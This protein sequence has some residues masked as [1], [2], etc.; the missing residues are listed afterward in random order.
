[1]QLERPVKQ[2]LKILTIVGVMAFIWLIKVTFFNI[3]NAAISHAQSRPDSLSGWLRLIVSIASLLGF[4]LVCCV[5]AVVLV[6]ILASQLLEEIDKLSLFDGHRYRIAYRPSAIHIITLLCATLLASV[7]LIS[8]FYGPATAFVFMNTLVFNPACLYSRPWT[9][10]T[11]AFSHGG[12]GHC[13]SNMIALHQLEYLEQHLGSSR[14]F[15]AFI[16]IAGATN[17][18]RY[19]LHALSLFTAGAFYLGASC[20]IMGLIVLQSLLLSQR[21]ANNSS[22]GIGPSLHS[23]SYQAFAKTL[24]LDFML[25]CY[26]HLF[27]P[28]SR[29]SHFG[30][31][32]S[33]AIAIAWVYAEKYLSFFPKILVEPHD[34]YTS[35][36]ASSIPAPVRSTRKR[37]TAPTKYHDRSLFGFRLHTGMLNLMNFTTSSTNA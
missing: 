32:I 14:F 29:V 11:S 26:R 19:T 3:I 1:M 17:F 34:R 30:H 4:K 7:Y 24:I 22:G 35:T 5:V 2:L 13:M 15:I 25:L 12:I 8:Y 16:V 36:P 21:S 23:R 33:G 27:D 18:V 9:L 31:I 37:S 28:K 6:T 10:I 20:S